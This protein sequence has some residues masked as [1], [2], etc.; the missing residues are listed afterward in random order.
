MTKKNDELAS[1]EDLRKCISEEISTLKKGE[2]I[3]ARANAIA[4]LLGKLLQSVKL[5]IEVHRYVTSGKRDVKGLNT[6]LIDTERKL[7]A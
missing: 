7:N 5:D 3:P 1:M 2:S 6:P 4:N